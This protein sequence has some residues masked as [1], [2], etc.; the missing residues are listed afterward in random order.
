MMV[1]EAFSV[2]NNLESESRE[3]R[4]ETRKEQVDWKKLKLEAE[5]ETCFQVTARKMSGRK[6]TR[7]EQVD[8]KKLKLE[9]EIEI[10]FQV[11]ARKM[12]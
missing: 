3:D 6:E 11:T 5:I 7:K 4:E 2:G 8:W 10:C 1:P 9:A 12:R